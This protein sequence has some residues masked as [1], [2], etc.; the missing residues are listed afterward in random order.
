[1]E[2]R[3][4]LIASRKHQMFPT[5]GH[6]QVN[7]AHR[8]ASGPEHYFE[9]GQ[10]VYSIGDTD[11]PAWLVL[12]GS[13]EVFRRDGLTREVQVT[14]HVAGQFSGEVNQ[15]AGRPAI[16][17]GRAGNAGCRALPFDAAHLRAL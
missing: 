16:A 17:G 11:A 9:P 4:T 7:Q 6:A 8:F 15:L 13:I 10:L 12:A 3:V 1:M 14:T 2:S 5:L